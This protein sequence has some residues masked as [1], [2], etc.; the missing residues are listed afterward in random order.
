MQ[1]RGGA[2]EEQGNGG[3]Q[4]GTTMR[5][6]GDVLRTWGTQAARW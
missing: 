4:D 1:G 6:G 3:G 5:S 2:E